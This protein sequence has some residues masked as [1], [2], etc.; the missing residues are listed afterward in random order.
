[1]ATP[2]MTCYIAVC[3][4]CKTELETDFI[5]HYPSV[6]EA[7]WAA[8]E[9]DW[10]WVGDKLYCEKCAEGKGVSCAGCDDLVEQEGDRCESCQQEERKPINAPS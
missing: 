5:V 10:V 4:D 3:D 7:T 8:T 9:H 6:G 2:E 1:M